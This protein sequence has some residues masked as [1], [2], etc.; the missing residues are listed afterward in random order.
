MQ[1]GILDWI[2]EWIK[3]LVENLLKLNKVYSLVNRAVPMLISWFTWYV[4]QNV[5]LNVKC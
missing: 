2:L 3:T 5:Y 1:H 4:Y